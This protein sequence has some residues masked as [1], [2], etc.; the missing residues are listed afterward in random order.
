MAKIPD[1]KKDKIK[2][3]E[4]NLIDCNRVI[5]DKERRKWTFI[6]NKNKNDKS[7]I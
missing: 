6:E 1:K 7:K 4:R 3:H 2:H 5:K